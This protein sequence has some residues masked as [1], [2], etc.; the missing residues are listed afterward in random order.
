MTDPKSFHDL[1]TFTDE[2]FNT[3]REG[4]L[5]LNTDFR[6]RRANAA[7]CDLF[8]VELEEIKGKKLFE[9][10]DGQW[11]ITE[12]RELLEQILPQ[13]K[14]ITD[15]EVEHD[16]PG[17]GHRIIY[18][19]A[20]QIDDMQLILIAFEDATKRINAFRE[21]EEA[22]QKLENR[23]EERTRQVRK[24]ALQITEVEQQERR[25]MAQI[26]HDDLQQVL[27][28]I[29]LTL[30]L[31]QK[32]IAEEGGQIAEEEISEVTEMVILAIDKT[33]QLSHD[34]N[35]PIMQT[36]KI[37]QILEW[38]AERY[39]EMYDLRTTVDVETDFLVKDN[40]V[41]I[42]L[43]KIVRE[44]LFNIVKHTETRNAIIKINRSKDNK[45][46]IRVIDEGGG[47]DL[48]KIEQTEG[49]GLFSILERINLLGGSFETD[50][51]LG[52][53]C[54]MAVKLPLEDDIVPD[55]KD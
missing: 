6:V 1:K 8:Q 17:V 44:L 21:L 27:F 38:L 49:F 31:I 20:H 35:P 14:T 11:D 28:S 51:V 18:L 54:R 13:N 42:V 45:M 24:L 15:Y 34:L 25:R 33:R 2:L 29:R 32:Q 23:V 30:N 5:V 10:G 37:S 16:F 41:R 7:F 50:V 9:L 22:R 40:N 48:E 4:F 12:L 47:F 3:L 52:R 36:E 43:L 39:D 26:L 19:N 53:G 46:I 55:K